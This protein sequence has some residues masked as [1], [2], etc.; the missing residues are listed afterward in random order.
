MK[1]K[2][3]VLLAWAYVAGNVVASVYNSKKWEDLE[4][5]L[6]EGKESALK[7]IW[8][9]IVDIHKK[10]FDEV[11]DEVETLDREEMKQKLLDL[12]EEFRLKAEE[13][14]KELKEKGPE[15][16]SEIYKKLEDLYEEKKNLIESYRKEIPTFIEEWKAKLHNY[17]EDIKKQIKK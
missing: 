5:E 3:L 16:A 8:N 1:L 17:F 10:L 11:K 7:I 14:I 13:L 6:L 12:A 9:N 4:K 15:Y 2:D